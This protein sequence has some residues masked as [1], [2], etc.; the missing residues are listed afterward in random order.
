MTRCLSCAHPVQPFLSFGK[1]PL[2]SGFLRREE[3]DGEFFTD[4]QIGWCRECS[5]VQLTKLVDPQLLFHDDY[6]YFA[7]T[8]AGMTSHFRE[9]AHQLS[10]EYLSTDDPFVV[11]IGS[12]D[13]IMLQNFAQAGVR[14]L[15][16][17]PSENVAQ[18][19]ISKGVATLK[20]FF[21]RDI[22]SHILQENGPADA[23]IG[24]NVISH[25]P[26]I[27]S[28]ISGVELLLSETGVFM[29]EEPY[30]GDIIENTAYDQFYDEHVF[31]FSLSSLSHA[32]DQHNLTI[33]DASP[34]PVHGGSMRYVIARNGSRQV[35]PAV[36]RLRTRES[37]LALSQEST[38]EALQE[39]IDQSRKD[40]TSLLRDLKRDGKRVVGYGATSK[41]TTVNN[42]CSIGPDLVEFVSDTTPAKHGKFTPGTHIPIK[43][44]E[45]FV[46]D[47]PDY[48]LLFAWNHR[49]EIMAKEQDFLRG[50][51]RFITFVPNVE[52]L[53]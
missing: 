28:L 39:R 38:F 13:G 31:Y 17:E 30:L 16:V 22:A 10:T 24:A 33:V 27:H 14:H 1:M 4:L 47:Y 42:Y 34:Q 51:G 2:A 8:S 43:P 49:E 19:A 50:G 23:V 9:F 41:S 52:I 20:R 5:L 46:A 53:D 32:L 15:G 21:D 40:L 48:A 44:Y 35:S 45:E 25:I 6:P 29:F 12:N 36:A 37:S 18:A 26:D 3:F 7:S 11:E